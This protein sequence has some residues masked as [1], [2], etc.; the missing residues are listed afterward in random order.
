[1]PE[2]IASELIT[3]LIFDSF[4]ETVEDVQ[5]IYLDGGTSLLETLATISAEE[6]S[7]PIS[8]DCSPLSAKVEHVTF[9]M[10][11]LERYM[12]G[13]NVSGTD[14]GAIW[15]TVG[16][17]TPEQWDAS[18][19]RL[20]AT[21]ERIVKEMHEIELWNSENALGGP[22]AIIIHTAYHLGEIRQAL[23]TLQPDRSGS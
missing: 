23:C 9:Y 7:R 14:W 6:A 16:T 1:M 17:V 19:A 15:R 18:R 11:V 20:R 8:A 3:S 2:M 22:L 4:K 21:Y 10:E 5:G 13:E 12:L